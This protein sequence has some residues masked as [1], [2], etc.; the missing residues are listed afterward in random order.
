M[1]VVFL[2]IFG[3]G[4]ALMGI[5][6][7]N[8]RQSVGLER[9]PAHGRWHE[10]MKSHQEHQKSQLP[11]AL[12]TLKILPNLDPAMIVIL[13]EYHALQKTI[14]VVRKLGGKEYDGLIEKIVDDYAKD[15]DIGKNIP[16]NPAQKNALLETLRGV[17]SIFGPSSRDETLSLRKIVFADVGFRLVDRKSTGD[18]EA[19]LPLKLTVTVITLGSP[20]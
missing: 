11:A 13:S 16:L 6:S 3:L 8:F 5:F 19:D 12:L 15:W 10:V 17:E 1:V 14:P 7:S 18:E 2:V 4:I 20:R 9:H